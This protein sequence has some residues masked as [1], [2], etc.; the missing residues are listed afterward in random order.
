MG[1]CEN[2]QRPTNWLSFK[3]AVRDRFSLENKQELMQIK[4]FRMKQTGTS[5][6]YIRAF[7]SS[8]SHGR[9]NT[10]TAFHQWFGQRLAQGS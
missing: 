8:S 2:S 9:P 4:L 3:S 6:D 1:L 10:C 5:E 7:S